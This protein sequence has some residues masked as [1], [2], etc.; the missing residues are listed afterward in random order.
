MGLRVPSGQV[1][2]DPG[3]LGARRLINQVENKRYET[4]AWWLMSFGAWHINTHFT[5]FKLD[6]QYGVCCSAVFSLNMCKSET[7][8]F[9][10][11]QVPQIFWR[12]ASESFAYD[13]T[14]EQVSAAMWITLCCIR[15]LSVLFDPTEICFSVWL[16]GCRFSADMPRHTHGEIK[17][18]CQ[19]WNT[20]CVMCLFNSL[21]WVC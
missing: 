3:L 5:S 13:T 6:L 1:G 9:Y 4:P 17:F 7:F 21:K 10:I 2:T 8:S 16:Y 11:F 20:V 14:Q 18:L 15:G 19:L 12:A